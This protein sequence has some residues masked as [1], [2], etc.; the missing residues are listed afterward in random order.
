MLR[1]SPTP[2]LIQIYANPQ[3]P[4]LIT[5]SPTSQSFLV[6]AMANPAPH[7]HWISAL[8]PSWLSIIKEIGR[9]TS[10]GISA[11]GAL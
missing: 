6:P 1:G 9:I 10:L 3:F 8:P 2:Q 5:I 11:A 7:C 4:T